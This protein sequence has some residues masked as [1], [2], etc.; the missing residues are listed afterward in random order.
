[1]PSVKARIMPGTSYYFVNHTLMEFCYFDEKMAIL[2]ALEGALTI[3]SQWKREH[4]I[5]IMA[6][7][8][9]TQDKVD[10]LLDVRGYRWLDI[11]DAPP[12]N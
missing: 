9:C 4:A 2:D 11:A 6:E 8:Y 7:E 10:N 1:M 3:W 12:V 5:C